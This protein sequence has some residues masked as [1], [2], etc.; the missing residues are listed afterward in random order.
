MNKKF[1]KFSFLVILATALFASWPAQARD[2]QLILPIAEAMQSKDAKEKLAGPV[3]Y[4]FKSEKSPTILHN[5]GY[6]IHSR[7]TNSAVKS[8]AEACNW[9]FLSA[10]IELKKDAEAAGANAVVNIASYY[11][12]Q[13]VANPV[14]FECHA[15]ALVAGVALKGDIVQIAK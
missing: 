2:T 12:K 6:F 10:M 13:A 15:G 9:A 8:D 4:F 5:F 11:N 7:K 3:R 1:S 14:M